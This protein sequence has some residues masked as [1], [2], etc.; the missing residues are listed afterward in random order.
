M[1]TLPYEVI[2]APYTV[3]RAP[4]KTAIPEISSAPGVA[5][6]RV[7]LSGDLNY[8]DGTGV[9][10]VP[11]QTIVEWRALGDSGTRK[12]FRTSEGFKVR[13]KLVDIRAEGLSIGINDNEVTDTASGVSAA[14]FRKVGLSRGFD[15]STGAL[16]VRGSVSPYG[17][18]WNSQY[19]VPIAA[20]TGNPTLAYV[21]GV[22]VGI[23]IEWTALIDPDAAVDERLGVYMAQDSDVNT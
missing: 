7:G 21:K 3:W 8:D 4:A 1:N 2:A 12:V 6:T 13:L 14:G 23:D 18:D 5:W 17:E 20:L 15:V 19:Y 9:I 22:P 11:E 16:L 10:I